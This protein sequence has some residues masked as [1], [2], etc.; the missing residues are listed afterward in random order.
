[1]D[2]ESATV[3]AARLIA[4]GEPLRVEEV[5]LP[6]PRD[7]DVRVRL[8]YGGV[9]PI[10][11]YGALGRV[12]PDLPLPRT[13][14]AEAAG[15]LDG[16]LVLAAGEGLGGARDGVWAQAA[17][18]P[19]EA[20]TDVPAGVAP[21]QAAAMGIAG[22]T[23]LNCVR[24][25]AGLSAEDRVVV[26]GASGGVGSMIVSL[27]DTAGATV[28]GQTGSAAKAPG[29]EE[30]GADRV[31][32]GGPDEIAGPLAEFRPTV[33]FDPLGDGFVAPVI[34][35]MAPRGRLV[36]FG[37]S[38]GAEV[39]FNLQL[40]YRKMLSVLGYGGGQLTREER[41][42]G[43]EAALEAVR[44]GELRVR[45]DDVLPLEQVNEAFQRLADRRVQGNLLL[46]LN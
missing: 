25:L 32:V 15:E 11:R 24:D 18:V 3:P 44:A 38:A 22:L 17:V 36:S 28:W 13:M 4:H 19:R 12:G 9:N 29:I 42:P 46:D 41:R 2:N 33:V 26:L 10:D 31:I 45:I 8:L 7:G 30:D 23:A 20:V 37:V 1:M 5:A 34:E 39:T 14:G 16:R 35:A 21:E 27:A 6:E 40:V 43:L